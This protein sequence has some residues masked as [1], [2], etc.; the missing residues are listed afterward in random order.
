MYNI[1][2]LFYINVK[3]V[4]K[5]RDSKAIFLELKFCPILY[6]TYYNFVN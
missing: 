5:K 6:K 4:Q 2:H 3:I 1:I